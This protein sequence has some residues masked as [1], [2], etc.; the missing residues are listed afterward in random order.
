MTFTRVYKYREKLSM[1]IEAEF[2]APPERVRQLWS[3]PRQIER[4]WG[5]RATS[6]VATGRWSR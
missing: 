6:R 3:D 4:R 1:T 2:A 5:P